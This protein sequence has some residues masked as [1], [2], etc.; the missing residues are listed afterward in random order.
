MA[1]G[2]DTH[3]CRA[4]VCK[5]AICAPTPCRSNSAAACSFATGHRRCCC[6]CCCAHP[7]APCPTLA[8]AGGRPGCPRAAR[9][10]CAWGDC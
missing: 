8:A 4:P 2:L 5:C 1:A 9:A 6:R 7:R 10:S 3:L